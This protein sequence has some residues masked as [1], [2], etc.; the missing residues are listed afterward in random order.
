MCECVHPGNNE[1]IAVT[2]ATQVDWLNR[3]QSIWRLMRALSPGTLRFC[4]GIFP[5]IEYPKVRQSQ[6]KGQG[7]S[8]CLG[9]SPKT[10]DSETK[11]TSNN[12]NGAADCSGKPDWH[13]FCPGNPA[14]CRRSPTSTSFS[15]KSFFTYPCRN[16][17]SLKVK[18]NKPASSG[19]NWRFARPTE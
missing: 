18:R 15:S 5:S 7:D 17:S 13:P 6:E 3:N 2:P 8:W 12:P 16:G 10:L 1:R 11:L 4:A 19:S 14:R 9:Q